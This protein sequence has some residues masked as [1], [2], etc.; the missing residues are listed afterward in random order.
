MLIL[1]YAEVSWDINAHCQFKC[2]YCRAEWKNGELARSVDDYLTV[3]EKLQT[4][5]Y[6]HHSTINWKL[7]GGEP[8]HFPHLTPVLRKIKEQ[9]STVELSTSGDDTWF[10][11]YSVL[12]FLDSIVFTYHSW[13]NSDIADFIFEQCLEKN[14]SVK[15]IVPMEPGK[16]LQAKEKID[17]IRSLGYQCDEQILYDISGQLYHGYTNADINQIFGREDNYQFDKSIYTPAYVDL[18]VV[19]D[20]DPIYTGQPCYAGVDWLHINHIG[21]ANYSQ[22]GGRSEMFNV[23]LPN[24]VPPDNHFPCS[25]NQCRNEQDHR[26][27]RILPF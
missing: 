5:R 14:I 9:P 13:Q 20:T 16:I 10:S 2:T 21:F 25:M 7:N 23:F 26:T 1:E 18:S 3:V 19:N 27:I 24:W 11:L 12:N 4:S 22:C 8:S 15:V 6:K 17:H